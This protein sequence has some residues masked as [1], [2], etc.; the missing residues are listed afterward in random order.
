MAVFFNINLQHISLYL[1]FPVFL[2]PDSSRLLSLSSIL[3]LC[4]IWL[5]LTFCNPVKE[6]EFKYED[7]LG[8]GQEIF[9][10]KET[11]FSE[12]FYCIVVLGDF[13]FIF[14]K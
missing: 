1:L 7:V 9:M 2:Q 12:C 3:Q 4:S 6:T 5:F 14:E 8:K 10:R 11:L 13:Y